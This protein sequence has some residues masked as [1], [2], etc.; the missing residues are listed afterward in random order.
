MR[1]RVLALVASVLALA[2][3]AGCRLEVAVDTE[4]ERNGA[5]VVRVEVRADAE[6]LARAPTALSD[7]RLDD[8]RATGWTAAGPESSPYGS[9]VVR[10][11]KPFASPEEGAAILRSLNGP[12]GPLHDV[13]LVS[14]VDG[15]DE[16]VQLN[17]VARL[18][19]GVEAFADSALVQAAGGVPFAGGVP[20][21]EGLGLTFSVAVPGEVVAPG[22]VVEDGR[23][24][25]TAP[26]APGQ[27]TVLSARGEWSASGPARFRTIAT[28][29]LIA[30]A[31]YAMGLMAFVVW[32]ARRRA[33]APGRFDA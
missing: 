26:L 14:T 6:L 32:R 18:D 12:Q 27:A 25:W 15:D 17:A 3:L 33:V 29:A 8:L 7:V 11:E 16:A 21:G 5:G 30:L 1:T 19:G 23:A 2:A 31:V 13:T 28:A 24:T 10:L 4:V 22:A 20:V 9:A